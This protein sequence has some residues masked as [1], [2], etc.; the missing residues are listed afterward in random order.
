MVIT[1]VGHYFTATMDLTE[2]VENRPGTPRRR[3]SI[4]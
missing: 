2:T 3:D 4:V 1:G